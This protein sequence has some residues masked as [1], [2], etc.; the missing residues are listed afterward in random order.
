MRQLE[1]SEATLQGAREGALLMAEDLALQQGLGNG[2]AIDGDEGPLSAGRKLVER[3]RGQLLARAALARDQ[4]RRGRGRGQLHEPV[5]LLHGR[6]G[7]HELAQ[8]PDL[9]DPSPQQDDLAERFPFLRSLGN[10][11]LEPAHVYGLHQVVVGAFLHGGHRAVDAALPREQDDAHEGKLLLQRLEKREAVELRHDEIGDDD[12]GQEDGGFLKSLLAVARLLD[13]V[14]PAGEQGRQPLAGSGFVV[15]DQNSQC[16][17][18][19]MFT[20]DSAGITF[21]NRPASIAGLGVSERGA[22]LKGRSIQGR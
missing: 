22:E 8:A 16:H 1:A 3:A 15:C 21:A 20:T 12:R 13:L 18:Y 7:A 9:S 17:A 6:A 5:D 11:R 2:G 10:E 19:P 14:S 4:D